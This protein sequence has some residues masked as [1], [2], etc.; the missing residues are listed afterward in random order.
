MNVTVVSTYP[1]TLDGLDK[2]L[3]ENHINNCNKCDKSFPDEDS[4]N[5]HTQVCSICSYCCSDFWTIKDLNIH[6]SNMHQL[7]CTKCDQVYPCKQVLESHFIS[8]HSI[9]CEKCCLLVRL[10]RKNT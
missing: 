3:K 4:L 6:V 8:K 2:H 5:R 1:L 9:P 10:K 7:L